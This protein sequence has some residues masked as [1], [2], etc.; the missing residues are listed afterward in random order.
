[1]DHNHSRKVGAESVVAVGTLKYNKRPLEFS[2]TPDDKLT[3][4]EQDEKR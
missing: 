2:V 4:V 1:M 3:C